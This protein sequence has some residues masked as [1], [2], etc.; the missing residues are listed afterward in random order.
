M[1]AAA[2]ESGDL[3][4]QAHTL[5]SYHPYGLWSHPAALTPTRCYL[6]MV[7]AAAESGD[8]LLQAHTLPSYHH[9]SPRAATYCCRRVGGSRSRQ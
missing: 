6:K 7:A 9:Y 5:P 2:A 3:L 8:L 1:V 4:L